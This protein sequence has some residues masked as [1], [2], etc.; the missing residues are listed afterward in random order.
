VLTNRKNVSLETGMSDRLYATLWTIAIVAVPVLMDFIFYD[1]KFARYSRVSIFLLV[2][3]SLLSNHKR[4]F[5]SKIRGVEFTFLTFLL[6]LVGTF[7][8]INNGGVATPNVALLLLIMFIVNTNNSMYTHIFK[9]IIFSVNVLIF[10]SVFAILFRINPSGIYV[11]SEGYPV[12]FENIG[13]PGRNVGLFSH[14]NVLGQTAAISFL[15][16]IQKKRTM[17]FSLF[18]LFCMFKSGS[19][20]A[21]IGVLAGLIILGGALIFK[22]L[23]NSRRKLIEFPAVIEGLTVLI[24]ASLFL[25]FFNYIDF[26]DPD[27]LT[28][29]ASIWQVSKEIYQNSALFGLGWGWQS[30]AIE[31][32]LLSVF[33]VSAHNAVLEIV[34]SAGLVG[35]IIFFL[36]LARGI[37]NFGNLTLTERV[38]LTCILISGVS[39][40]YI[41]LQYPTIQ[42]YLFFI[43]LLSAGWERNETN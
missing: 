15:A 27:R 26:L 13:I 29:R 6:Y 32:Q 12:L 19:R 20:T 1:S 31:S 33:S 41:N 25:F 4:F 9:M 8:S 30:R 5:S 11:S 42:T 21:I 2:G 28:G 43:T 36:I 38:L 10:I 7:S 18:P 24:L 17:I 40:A 3:F 14:P 23:R 35:L 22:R 39:E 37:V 34:F 16:L